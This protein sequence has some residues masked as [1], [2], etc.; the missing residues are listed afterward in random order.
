MSR[1]GLTPRSSG[2]Y[3]R[4]R[5]EVLDASNTGIKYRVLKH[6]DLEKIWPLLDKGPEDGLS[7]QFSM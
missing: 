7:L 2:V 5:F 1:R 6:L 4:A 3:K